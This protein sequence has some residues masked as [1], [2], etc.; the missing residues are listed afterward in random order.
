MEGAELRH[1]RERALV[2]AGAMLPH[3]KKPP[4]F[5][6]FVGAKPARAEPQRPEILQAMCDALAQAWGAEKVMH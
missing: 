6:E 3:L 1:Q 2:W 5:D 4:K